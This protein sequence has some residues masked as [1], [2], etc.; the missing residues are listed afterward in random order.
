MDGWNTTFLLGRPIFR[1]YV[2][3]REGI[4]NL[5]QVCTYSSR[6]GKDQTSPNNSKRAGW[7]QISPL[8]K[9]LNIEFN[10]F[11]QL[12]YIIARPNPLFLAQI[13][14]RCLLVTVDASEIPEKIT[15]HPKGS[16]ANN[17]KHFQVK[18]PSKQHLGP[19]FAPK[20]GG[21]FF[22]TPPC[23]EDHPSY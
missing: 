7:F 17:L 10:H 1:G 6:G 9:D 19:R 18:K 8:E 11:L 13:N 21:E 14:Q 4:S 16:W 12:W 23:L 2:S 22:P 15:K 20:D 3:F 5:F